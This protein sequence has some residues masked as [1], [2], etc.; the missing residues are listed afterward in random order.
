MNLKIIFHNIGI[1][2]PIEEEDIVERLDPELNFLQL[3]QR[4]E[5]KTVKIV[6]HKN[7]ENVGIVLC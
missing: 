1:L 5:H 4:F 2:L 3:E 6:K 7:E